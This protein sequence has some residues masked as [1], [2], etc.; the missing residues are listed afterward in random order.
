MS[1]KK[2]LESLVEIQTDLA[3][4]IN[5]MK[6]LSLDDAFI[7]HCDFVLNNMTILK[8]VSALKIAVQSYNVY[9]KTGDELE[10]DTNNTSYDLL[11][12]SI[13]DDYMDDNDD[14]N[15]VSV[16]FE[17][18]TNHH[19]KTEK[20]DD[21]DY[22]PKRETRRATKAKKQVASKKTKGKRGPKSAANRRTSQGT[23]DSDPSIQIEYR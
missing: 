12:D 3:T 20:D 22:D 21:A 17:S 7:T 19:I 9:N 11:N 6:L 8:A 13:M 15:D 10:G 18:D 23:S 14:N 4:V 1:G 16:S 2:L 5:K